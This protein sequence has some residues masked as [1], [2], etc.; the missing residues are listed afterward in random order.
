M[1]F[2]EALTGTLT[3]AVLDGAGSCHGRGSIEGAG[4]AVGAAVLRLV[5]IS[6]AG[7]AGNQAGAGEVARRTG[8]CRSRDKR[9][10]KKKNYWRVGQIKPWNHPKT[11]F[12]KVAFSGSTL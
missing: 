12:L 9:R 7:V 3:G 1:S 8:D 2:C 6:G 10:G 4:E 11:V 5:V